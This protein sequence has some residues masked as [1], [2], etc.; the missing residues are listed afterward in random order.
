MRS[1]DFHDGSGG[2]IDSHSARAS[3]PSPPA[4]EL[5]PSPSAPERLPSSSWVQGLRPEAHARTREQLYAMHANTLEHRRQLA[6]ERD[7]S[8]RPKSYTMA[9]FYRK[10]LP[11]RPPQGP[12]AFGSAIKRQ[13]TRH[14][15]P[16]SSYAATPLPAASTALPM[17]ELSSTT[18]RPTTPRPTTPMSERKPYGSFGSAAVGRSAFPAEPDNGVPGPGSYDTSPGHSRSAP[19]MRPPSDPPRPRDVSALPHTVSA[20]LSVHGTLPD[21]LE[22]LWHRTAARA[23]GIQAMRKDGRGRAAAIGGAVSRFEKA[24][25]QAVPA[26]CVLSLAHWLRHNCAL[27]QAESR[28]YAEVLVQLGC[29]APADLILLHEE[30]F[31]PTIKLLHRR[32]IC[33]AAALLQPMGV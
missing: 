20:G 2:P 7:E 10:A 13:P 18:P 27:P 3:H 29:D 9:E 4:P 22:R 14:V 33:E 30:D 32:R 24:A 19:V 15:S 26:S 1:P 21:S 23:A 5:H 8:M 28:E 25:R 16:S 31:P 17:G 12:A 11:R 6:S